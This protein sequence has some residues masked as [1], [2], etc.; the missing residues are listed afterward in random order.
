LT[1]HQETKKIALG[2]KPLWKRRPP[3]MR[4]TPSMV[5]TRLL[6]SLLVLLAVAR[7]INAATAD[8]ESAE[9]EA[10][11]KEGQVRVDAEENKPA[12][13]KPPEKP[14]EAIPANYGPSEQIHQSTYVA[15]EGHH[16]DHQSFG[17]Q[18][19][20]GKPGSRPSGGYGKSVVP[21]KLNAGD[22]SAMDVGIRHL[23]LKWKMP[24]E[25]GAII[26]G[27]RVMKKMAGFKG[28]ATVAAQADSETQL[29]VLI[30]DL[31]GGTEYKFTIIALYN[32]G[33]KGPESDEFS[34]KTKFGTPQPPTGV[35][36]DNIGLYKMT[37]HWNAP[38][39][40]G[41]KPILGYRITQQEDAESTGSTVFAPVVTNTGYGEGGP[42]PCSCKMMWEYTF[43]GETSNHV[44]CASTPS[45][46][47]AKTWCEV[48]GGGKCHLKDGGQ[49]TEDGM[50]WKECDAEKDAV[51]LATSYTL[52]TCIPGGHMYS[53]RVEAINIIGNSRHSR[54]S[55]QY[56]TKYATVPEPPP[57]LQVK[58]IDG[59]SVKLVWKTAADG[60]RKLSGYRV[61][62]QT[63]G[64]GPFEVVSENTFLNEH[65]D[66]T[67]RDTEYVAIGLEGSKKYIFAVQGIND[68]GNGGTSK[69]QPISPLPG[70]PIKL[71]RA[72]SVGQVGPTSLQLE[73]DKAEDG[74]APIV[75]YRILMR[76]KNTGGFA[77]KVNNTMST[78]TTMKITGLKMGGISYEFVVQ[79]INSVGIGPRSP[80]S[81]AV[82]TLY[83]D[84]IATALSVT[85]AMESFKQH[86]TIHKLW[87][88][89]QTNER[90]AKTIKQKDV[91]TKRAQESAAKQKQLAQQLQMRLNIEIALANKK[92]TMERKL[93]EK[94]TQL[95]IDVW[96][97]KR[98]LVI[99]KYDKLVKEV[100]EKAESK[101]TNTQKVAV[102]KI[103]KIR[104]DMTGA[105]DKKTATN[106]QRFQEAMN[107]KD[108][109]MRKAHKDATSKFNDAERLAA[110]RFGDMREQN[111]KTLQQE[112]LD[113][114][115]KLQKQESLLRREI[116]DLIS[117]QPKQLPMEKAATA[118]ATAE[119]VKQMKKM[120]VV[121]E[122]KS[123]PKIDIKAR[124]AAIAKATELYKETDEK[125]KVAETK[126]VK[127]KSTYDDSKQKQE[128][129][130]V[131]LQ[132]AEMAL[133]T[134]QNAAKHGVELGS[135]Q[136]EGHL[137]VINLVSLEEKNAAPP[138]AAT[139]AA[140][141]NDPI[142]AEL[143]NKLLLTLKKAKMKKEA[144][145][146]V[147]KEN[148]ENSLK[149]REE[150]ETLRMSATAMKSKVD[151]AELQVKAAVEEAKSKIDTNQA[152]ALL[153][154][155]IKEHE[156]EDEAAKH[157]M[158]VD[159]ESQIKQIDDGAPVMF[160][161]GDKCPAGSTP[162]AE[163]FERMMPEF[164]NAVIDMIKA[165]NAKAMGALAD[166]PR[167]KANFLGSCEMQANC[168]ALG[169]TGQ[170]CNP[171]TMCSA[172]SVTEKARPCK[173]CATIYAIRRWREL[174]FFKM[175]KCKKGDI[176]CEPTPRA[177]DLCT[178][179]DVDRMSIATTVCHEVHDI[180]RKPVG[181]DKWNPDP[182]EI[183]WGATHCTSCQE[184]DALEMVHAETETGICRSFGRPDG[185]A[186]LNAMPSCH[187]DNN[188]N[189]EASSNRQVCTKIY[190]PAVIFKG[191]N[192]QAFMINHNKYAY[193]T[194]DVRKEIRCSP[195]DFTLRSIKARP[196]DGGPKQI[197]VEKSV[198]RTNKQVHCRNVCRMK[199]DG[200]L[201]KLGEDCKV[202]NS[203]TPAFARSISTSEFMGVAHDLSQY[204]CD[205]K[206]CSVEMC[207]HASLD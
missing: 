12:E 110:L 107:E 124:R 140:D 35:Y 88:L 130:R 95:Q 142:D 21:S 187:T 157:Q 27:Y 53:Y 135:A 137:G 184:G 22:L 81:K 45:K 148:K 55:D 193:V 41:G 133:K 172:G 89:K 192:T 167:N 163:D 30:D 75:G 33:Q 63:D 77:S 149:A 104:E 39:D 9:E 56:K 151:E 136:I 132:D 47:T 68:K 176:T 58:A 204:D 99:D 170:N 28:N 13:G 50:F 101:I 154:K 2:I 16:P 182:G 70:L 168:I 4:L 7:V 26:E 131:E 62:A 92:L 169:G 196:A 175:L 165:R 207:S 152:A 206:R 74:G 20:F 186:N 202:D 109:D 91:E 100:K 60:G 190:R 10:S 59:T 102:K 173:T 97:S 25:N 179:A 83:S 185:T 200:T 160:E 119:K 64:T 126:F 103:G 24:E 116:S 32:H 171:E 139:A 96:H 166:T 161:F 19:K 72:P 86:N 199:A 105:C 128:K 14:A 31:K 80:S 85:E 127:I 3:G 134:A 94:N 201:C 46:H 15:D 191:S 111:E 6:L 1:V 44:G 34:V 141:P 181:K 194:C 37:L 115:I 71:K 42:T 153:K 11:A 98:D 118:R 108:A 177:W 189:V 143:R 5:S 76:T 178:K 164:N 129:A 36:A 73:W 120:E 40:T 158:A 48:Y 203:W 156:D 106:E 79:G 195:D 52:D 150:A 183:N 180:G 112:R 146:K 125:A 138:A 205:P 159:A 61:S 114:K 8:P 29:A 121:L 66:L 84:A 57:G 38:P 23:T 162:G 18:T 198:C 69:S 87:E 90:S 54:T 65:G 117:K 144:I 188:M 43:K 17:D 49:K 155:E 123:G 67:N 51:H 147:V 82:Q 93:G 113:A 174:N 145:D 78:A 122:G 197:V